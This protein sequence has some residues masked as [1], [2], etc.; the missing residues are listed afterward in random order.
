MNSCR[1]I[2]LYIAFFLFQTYCFGVNHTF[3]K[4]SI[5]DGLCNNQVQ[6]IYKDSYGF[7]WIGTLEGID[8]Y[9]GVEVKHFSYRFNKKAGNIFCITEDAKR[10]LWVGTSNGLFKHNKKKDIFEHIPLGEEGVPV[11]TIE[12]LNDSVFCVGT[13]NGLFLVNT[14]T[15]QSEELQLTGDSDIE[16]NYITGLFIDNHNNCWLT[17]LIGL[18]KYNIKDRKGELFQCELEPHEGCNSFSSIC[19]I[20]NK[21]YLGTFQNGLVE[22]DISTKEF[23]KGVGLDCDIVVKVYS[24]NKHRIFVCTDG[25]G[26]KV[27]D[28]HTLEVEDIKRNQN[29][30]ESII[31]NTVYCFLLDEKDR[32]WIGTYSEGLCFSKNISKYFKFHEISTDHP[33]INRN[34]RSFYFSPDGFQFF[35]TRNGLGVIDNEGE[36]KYY[37]VETTKSLQSNIILSIYPYKD[38]VLIGTYGG[39]VSVYSKT[40]KTIKP[41]LNSD[42]LI[43]EKVY[44][45]ELDRLD[46]LWISSFNGLYRYSSGNDSLMHIDITNSELAVNEIFDIDID[47]KDRVWVGSMDGISVFSLKGRKLEK[48]DLGEI[49][50]KTFKTNYI[51]EDLEGN[52]WICTE[53]EGLI[54]INSDLSSAVLFKEENGLI[55]NNI[56]AIVECS[57]G[58]YWISTNKGLSKYSNKSKKF[59]KYSI[60]EGVP[61]LVFTL[62]AIDLSS[63]GTLYLGNEKG[64]V[65]FTPQDVNE[66]ELASQIQ[67][68]DFFLSGREVKSG[69]ESVLSE[70]ITNTKEIDLS[71]KMNNIGFRFVALN[72]IPALNNNYQYK[73][74]GFDAEWRPNGN[75]NTVFYDRVKPGNYIFKVRKSNGNVDDDK[76]DAEVKLSIHRSFMHSPYFIVLLI[77][78]FLAG[79]YFLYNY[80]KVLQQKVKAIEVQSVKTEKYKGSRVPEEQSSVVIQELKKLMVEQKYYLNADLKLADLSNELNHSINE[81]SQVLNQDLNQSFPDFVNKYRIREVKRLL[82]EKAYEKFTFMAIAQQCGFKSKTSFYRI[83]KNETGKTPADYVKDLE[84]NNQ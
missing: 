64:L 10:H 22:F 19:S 63:D 77:F 61:G 18:I 2:L 81:I 71:Y 84:T 54:M 31:S 15:F 26:L 33:E 30:S 4:L 55:S 41:F 49:V 75:K 50:T 5:D 14:N 74:E 68:T 53:S 48:I 44:A 34:I 43:H 40:K 46:N 69:E 79:A 11:Q 56:C 73:L 16:S 1:S 35:G 42:E 82:S 3:S 67:F 39:G 80:I 17:T 70:C 38:D 23:T 47:S 24:D 58:E 20:G 12:S 7:I 52:M 45:F 6:V 27:I 25:G 62:G 66:T 72:Y 78:V 21:L 29:D 65:Y 59:T 76:Y 32:F 37:Q 60:S 9:D 57:P 36:F 83:F 51:Y 13:R 8:R 28:L